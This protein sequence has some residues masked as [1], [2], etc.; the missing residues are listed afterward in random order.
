METGEGRVFPLRWVRKRIDLR[1]DQ[2][3]DGRGV[4][5]APTGA[6]NGLQIQDFTRTWNRMEAVSVL[7]L[8]QIA[9]FPNNEKNEE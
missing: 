1:S 7:L 3:R 6:G 2:G 4:R 5:P 9:L 8:K